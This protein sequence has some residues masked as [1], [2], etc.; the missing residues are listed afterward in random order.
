MHHIQKSILIVLVIFLGLCFSPPFSLKI[1]LMG[2]SLSMLFMLLAVRISQS[3]V[4]YLCI[5]LFSV[6]LPLTL[7]EGYAH[8]LLQIHPVNNY[9]AVVTEIHGKKVTQKHPHIGYVPIAN[10]SV[11]MQATQD[12]SV[13][14]KA[15]YTFDGQ[16]RRITPVHPHAKTAVLLFGCSFTFGRGLNDT[17]TMAWQLGKNLGESYQV[18]NF[19]YS[20][21]GQH[22]ALAII[23]H[24]LPDLHAYEKILTYFIVMQDQVRRGAGLLGRGFVDGP[25]YEIQDGKVVRVGNFSQQML[26]PWQKKG[27]TWL[28]ETATLQFYESN[29]SERALPL[30]TEDKRMALFRAILNTSAEKLHQ[31]YGQNSSTV[32]IWPVTYSTLAQTLPPLHAH[33][34]IINMDSWLPNAAQNMGQY[35][36][37]IDRHPN[38]LANTYMARGLTQ[39]VQ[40][41]SK[42]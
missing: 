17:E 10:T 3:I 34:P 25:R 27:L 9:R 29:L 12:D 38:A 31:R 19:A 22:N 20:G 14:F 13:L 40:Q 26:L 18:Y 8:I 23:E 11:T 2:L 7:F 24:A 4:K 37:P 41:Q 32:L 15:N 21:Y 16:G 39:L 6:C 42:P 28:Q 1:F 30:N 36:I 5:L 33:I 35:I